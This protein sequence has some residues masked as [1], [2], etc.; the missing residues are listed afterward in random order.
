MQ[1][2]QVIL[3]AVIVATFLALPFFIGGFGLRTVTHIFMFAVLAS[4]LNIMAGFTG[5]APFGNMLFFG[6][7]AYTTAM[8]I[9]YLETPLIVGLLASG[10]VAL[11]FAILFG[12]LFLRLRGQYF[13]LATT[14]A[15]EAIR[16]VVTNVRATGGGQGITV[17]GIAGSPAFINTFFYYLMFALVVLIVTF[18]WNLDRSRLGYAFKAIR[19]NEEAAG[20]MGIDTTRYKIT[21]WSLSALFTGVVG[22]VYALWLSYID[23]P[24]V[25]NIMWTVRMFVIL[26]LGGIGTVFGPVLGAFIIEALSELVWARFLYL[27]M[28]VLG[29]LIIIVVMFMPN[30][31]VQLVKERQAGVLLILRKMNLVKE[32]Q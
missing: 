5:Y 16:Q 4:A 31:I 17:P 24:A 25:F 27:H 10:I 26:L 6:V 8:L 11:L 19:A 20:V 12:V 14:G 13:A 3:L 2:R 32:R 21:A 23:P 30:G 1:R 7:G 29:L 9:N 28:G 22:G 15:A 18:V